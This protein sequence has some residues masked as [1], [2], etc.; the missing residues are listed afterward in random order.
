MRKPAFLTSVSTPQAQLIWSK[1]G[2]VLGV[3]S[4]LFIL[5]LLAYWG[6]G[7][8]PGPLF[9]AGICLLSLM[10]LT[11]GWVAWWLF[12]SPLPDG[13]AVTLARAIELRQHVALLAVV[14]GLLLLTGAF[15]DEVWHRIYGTGAAVNDFFWRPHLMIYGSMAINSLF[16]AGALLVALRGAGDIRRRFRAEP[17]I[18]LVGLAS[19]Y[20][21]LS[22]P[23]D[24]IWHQIYGVDLSAWSLPHLMLSGGSALVMLLAMSILLSLMPRPEWRGLG[25][26]RA[27]ELLAIVLIAIGT[28][29]VTVILTSEWEDIITI[30]G[31]NATGNRMSAF[32]SR[33]EWLYPVVLL[34]IGVAVSSL[35]IHALRRAGAATLVALTILGARLLLFTAFGVWSSN[36]HMGFTTQLLILPPAIALD[37]WYALRRPREESA[38]TLIGGSL[39]AGVVSLAVAL[40]AIPH[41]LIYPRVN[42][43][44]APLM[45]LFGLVLAL[46]S[47]WLGA[48]GG[49][50]FGSLDRQAQETVQLNRRAAWVGAGALSFLAAF[51]VFFIVTAIPPAS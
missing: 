46:W 6:G 35:A 8:R 37:V 38:T 22:G 29:L 33:P 36:L 3:G 21:A 12:A 27:Y 15:W 49:A 31:A 50:W 34:T 9:V 16:A 45:V 41:M 5:G 44:T 28:M 30:G 14:S 11:A 2:L 24:L 17:L 48:R 47:G 18:G 13:Q 7:A 19:A 23:S 40:L 1:A 43:T 4:S 10:I 26:L 20:L 51:T 42:A 39:L 25:G 32:W